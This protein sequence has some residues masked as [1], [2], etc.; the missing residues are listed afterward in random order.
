MPGTRTGVVCGGTDMLEAASSE[1][2]NEL[3]LINS[4]TQQKLVNPLGLATS[5]SNSAKPLDGSNQHGQPALKES[6]K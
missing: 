6:N 5:R 2:W 3:I 1:P 4:K